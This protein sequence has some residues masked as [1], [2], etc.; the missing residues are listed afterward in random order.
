IDGLAG[1][2]AF[3]IPNHD[4]EAFAISFISTVAKFPSQTVAPFASRDIQAEPLLLNMIGT[5]AT[6]IPRLKPNPN[7]NMPKATVPIRSVSGSKILRV[8]GTKV[9]MR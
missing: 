1:N 9:A 8:A 4:L 7:I 3:I 6:A 5:L 2:I